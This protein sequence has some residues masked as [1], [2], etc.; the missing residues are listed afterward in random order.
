MIEGCLQWQRIGLGP[1]IAVTGATNAYMEAEDALTAW[2]EDWCARDP[3]AWETSNALYAAWNAWCRGSGEYSG[4]QKQFSQTLLDR[5]AE[6]GITFQRKESGRGFR[7][8]RLVGDAHRY[9][10]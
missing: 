7:G 6:L 4:S 9:P 3:N 8:L 10:A 1:P 5:S 2:I